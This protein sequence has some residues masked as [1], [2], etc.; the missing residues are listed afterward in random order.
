MKSK[1]DKPQRTARSI[2]RRLAVWT[3]AASRHSLSWLLRLFFILLFLIIVTLSYLHLV[4]LPAYFTDIFLDRMASQGYFLQIERLTLEIDRG[5]VAR[6]ARVFLSETAPEPFLEAEALAVAVNPLHAIRDRQLTPVLIIANGTLRAHLGNSESKAREGSRALQMDHI[7]FRLSAADTGFTLREFSAKLLGI[8]FRGRGTLYAAPKPAAPAEPVEPDAPPA[9]PLHMAQEA[10]QNSPDWLLRVVEQINL[11]SFKQPPTADFAF[12][13]YPA[14]PEA[15]EITLQFSARDG[16]QIRGVNF[17]RGELNLTWKNQQLDLSNLQIYKDAGFLGAAGQI[18]LTNQVVAL[19]LRNTLPL[20]TF[21]DLMPLDIQSKAR[22]I[23]ADAHFPLQLE[24]NIGPAP[25]ASAA[26]HLRGRIA[27]SKALIRDVPIDDLSIS[28]ERNGPD[29]LVHNAVAQLGSEPYPSHMKIRNGRYNIPERRYEAHCSG[30]LNPHVLKPILSTG[31]RNIVEWFGVQEPVQADLMVGGEVGNPAISCYG[32]VQAT[33]FTIQGVALQSFQGDLNITNEVMHINGATII[34]PEGIARGEAHMAF[35]NQTVRLDLESTLDARD[36]AQMIG[37]AA[38]EFMRPFQLNGPVRLHLEG[39]LD[40]CNFSLNQLHAQVHAQRFGYD[41]WEADV[42]DFD[43]HIQGRRIAFTNAQAAAYGGQM[44][45]HGVLYPVGNDAT[46][47][48][49]VTWQ[50]ADVRLADILAA[51]LGKP[52]K[53]LSGTM[54][55]GGRIG[56]YI[57]KGMGPT[58]VGTGQ[59]DIRDGL[60]FQTKLFSGLTAILSKIFPDF[61]WFAQ[62]DASGDYAIR[63]SHIYSP[64]IRLEGTVF[65]VKAAGNYSFPGELDYR[66]EVQL[67]RDSMIAKLV[68]LATMPVTRLLE[69]RL[70]GTFEDPRWRPLNLNIAD[71]LTGDTKPPQTTA[72]E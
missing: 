60:L 2:G 54:H 53:E 40:Y 14:H 59:M 51:S 25:L 18:N 29:I 10:L 71:L 67:L 7:H 33:N 42:A 17:S 62:T 49:D 38:A 28:F 66:V 11:L 32:P 37:P 15:N 45:G 69:F 39:L 35:S 27:F 31:M 12:A 4:G 26:E 19:E 5:L 41:R 22:Q 47:R 43:L 70:T 20:N 1:K 6:N 64:N 34:R 46:W 21:L 61:N 50:G 44:S 63:N 58:V 65:G 57:G 3:W 48:Y 56:G 72:A 23:V 52:V 8:Q 68:R 9:N 24:V 55:G 13:A 16:G 36:T 30:T